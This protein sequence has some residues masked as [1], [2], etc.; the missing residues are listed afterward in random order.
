MIRHSHELDNEIKRAQLKA[1]L[2]HELVDYKRKKI[3]KRELQK[4]LEKELFELHYKTTDARVI[5]FLLNR[6]SKNRV[7]TCDGPATVLIR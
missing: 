6:Y 7:A 5:R 1:K 4:R 3:V 2:Q